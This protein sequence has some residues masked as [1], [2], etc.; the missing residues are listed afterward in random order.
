MVKLLRMM[1]LQRSDA[2]GRRVRKL[3]PNGER[4]QILQRIDE[5]AES[6][7]QRHREFLELRTMVLELSE[8]ISA[9]LQTT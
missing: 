1:D 9:H 5:L 8:K 6:N 7:R 4:D 3:F 2:D